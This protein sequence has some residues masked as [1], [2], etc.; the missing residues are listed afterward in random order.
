MYNYSSKDALKTID[1]D[2]QLSENV[3]F[4]IHVRLSHYRA[5]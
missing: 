3:L 1:I 2:L 5:L 4:V